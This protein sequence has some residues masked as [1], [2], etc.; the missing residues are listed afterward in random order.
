MGCMLLAPATFIHVTDPPI[1][2]R[3]G[4]SLVGQ[5]IVMGGA[6]Y[7]RVLF[8]EHGPAV[9]VEGR[10]VFIGFCHIECI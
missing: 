5:H 4:D 7:G 9:I 10:D 6:T 8:A 2:L 3:D 1:V